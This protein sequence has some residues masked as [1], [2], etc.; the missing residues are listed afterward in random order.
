[1]PG[2]TRAHMCAEKIN[3]REAWNPFSD[4]TI[5]AHYYYRR[6]QQ[7]NCLHT[8]VSV[9]LDFT[10]AST[11]PKLEDLIGSA[12]KGA[13]LKPTDTVDNPPAALKPK[14]CSVRTGAGKPL[15]RYA[16]KQQLYLVV[17]FGGFFDTQRKQ[18]GEKEIADA[19]GTFPEVAVKRI[20][21]N[22]ILGCLSFVRVF[23]GLT[24]AEGFTAV[25][26][27][28]GSLRPT[29]EAC[30]GFAGDQRIARNLL[31]ELTRQFN[32]IAGSMPFRACW[33]GTGGQRL[34][35]PLRI[36]SVQGADGS[37]LY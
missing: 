36:V 1:M 27:E 4:P 29:I 18:A 3:L 9:T 15:Q 16:D 31:R 22:N 32:A 11:F 23:H 2:L 20:P 17:L 12:M 26:D 33:T 34:P 14:L 5:R 6:E 13:A 7:D 25:F 21:A 8:V 37:Y 28:K 30:E 35:N 10:T 24:E 19:S